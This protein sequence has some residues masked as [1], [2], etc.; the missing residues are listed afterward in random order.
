MLDWVYVSCRAD[1]HVDVGVD[2]TTPMSPGQKYRYWCS[3]ICLSAVV[4]PL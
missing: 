4:S 2:S 3:L 1:S